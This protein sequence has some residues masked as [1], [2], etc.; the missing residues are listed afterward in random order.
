MKFRILQVVLM[1]VALAL[2]NMADASLAGVRSW[3]CYYGAVFPE[4]APPFY[5]LYILDGRAHPDL[6]PLH[7]RGAKAV[8]YVSVGEIREDDPAFRG[9]PRKLKLERNPDWKGAWRVD[10]RDPRWHN[11][12]LETAIPQVLA[13]GFDGIFLDTIDVAAF[14]E[15]DRKKKGAIDAAKTLIAAIR[16]RYPKILI[17]LNNGLFLAE[18]VG[19][20]IDALVVEDVYTSYDFKKKKYLVADNA[21]TE[22]R[23][24][25]LRPFRVRFGKPV[26]ALEYVDPADAEGI[27]LVAA[28][29]RGDGLLPYVAEINLQQIFFYP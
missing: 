2:S 19:S 1:M 16:E 17:I 26:L 3:V 12:L 15:N 14:L 11:H 9:L 6:A 20:M 22:A 27:A 18:S 28:R 13:Q 5:D 23:L 24:A 25:G 8:G 10:L 7:A 29:A 4:P 21:W